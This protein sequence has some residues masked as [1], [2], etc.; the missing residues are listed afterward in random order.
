MKDPAAETAGDTISKMKSN[1]S[2]ATKE[3]GRLID[4]WVPVKIR[5]DRMPGVSIGI[6]YRG[7]LVYAKGFGFADLERKQKA[8]EKTLYHIASI[9]KVFTAA[10]IMQLVE[11]GGLR[12]DDKVS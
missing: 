10:S 2:K 8:D 7:K 12:L 9:S 6:R 4:L 3:V 5:Y 11:S 1:F